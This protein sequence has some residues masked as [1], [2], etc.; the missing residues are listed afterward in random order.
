MG[1]D[2]RDERREVEED[3]NEDLELTQEDAEQVSGGDDYS[4]VRAWPMK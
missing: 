1:E 2:V 4:L 3:V